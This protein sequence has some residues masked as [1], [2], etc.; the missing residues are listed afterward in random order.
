MITQ[1]LDIEKSL[2]QSPPI[3]SDGVI[4][5]KRIRTQRKNCTWPITQEFRVQGKDKD[6]VSELE[7][8]YTTY[9]LIYSEPVQVVMVDPE[10]KD[11]F[12]GIA[13]SHRDRAQ[14][15]LGWEYAI[16]D[17]VEFET[18]LARL[19]F[20]F[21]SNHHKPAQRLTKF[22]IHK[23]ITNAIKTGVITNEDKS[24]KSFIDKIAPS[25][26]RS[27]ETLFN[28]YRQTHSKFENL[29]AFGAKEAN[30][31]AKE[32]GLPYKGAENYPNTGEYGYIK[33]PG[34]FQT[35]LYGGL[36]LWLEHGE[37]IQL[38]G[39]ITNPDPTTL[40]RRRKTEQKAFDEMNELC[41]QIAS[42]MTGMDTDEVKKLGR[43][44]FKYNGFLP[45]VIS[46]DPGKGGLPVET[47]LVDADGNPFKK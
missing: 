24:V 15:N 19:T 14:H 39:Y 23:G 38:T 37:D 44:P 45:Q 20:G 40:V 1:N 2:K 13:G 27:K 26:D 7:E 6:N 42:K 33:E 5:K 43:A 29:E 21:T 25:S 22:D 18:P 46:A 16:Y 31:K 41:Y 30:N 11:R 12:V 8:S 47:E 10:N 4:F 17:V 3:Y 36:K 35:V 9:N 32:L 34:G 28:T